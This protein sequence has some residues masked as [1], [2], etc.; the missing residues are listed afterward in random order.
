MS[1]FQKLMNY[2]MYSDFKDIIHLDKRVHAASGLMKSVYKIRALYS[3][4]LP[5]LMSYMACLGADYFYK[6]DFWPNDID[7][8]LEEEEEEDFDI[9]EDE[10]D[11][12]KLNEELKESVKS[13]LKTVGAYGSFGILLS[14]LDIMCLR[15]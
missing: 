9:N 12:D 7:A 10:F 8:E 11:D 6:E 4:F 2:R 5:C 1:A 3:G 15:M 14:S 13:L